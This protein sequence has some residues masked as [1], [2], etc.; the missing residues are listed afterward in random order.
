MSKLNFSTNCPKNNLN[1]QVKTEPVHGLSGCNGIFTRTRTYIGTYL[2]VMHIWGIW[3]LCTYE[4]SDSYAYMYLSDSYAHMRYLAQK[5]DK[6][7]C[8]CS[9]PVIGWV[10]MQ[11]FRLFLGDS[12]RHAI[13]LYGCFVEFT[14]TRTRFN[15]N[16]VHV[17]NKQF[18]GGENWTSLYILYATTERYRKE[19]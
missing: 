19:I 2:T 14:L 16:P 7:R 3:Q 18:F 6:N 9:N 1:L 12:V 13:D 4:V 5:P 17:I 10:F 8:I 11:R 15:N